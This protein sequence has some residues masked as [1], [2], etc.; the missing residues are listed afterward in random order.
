MLIMQ[1]YLEIENYQKQQRVTNFELGKLRKGLFWD[2]DITKLDFDK[3]AVAII[4]RVFE[5]GNSEEKR[6]IN[7]YYGDKRVTEVLGINLSGSS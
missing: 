2:T 3:H 6:Y 5:R 1:T 4:R 7:D